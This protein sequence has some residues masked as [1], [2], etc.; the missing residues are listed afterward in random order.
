M[1]LKSLYSTNAVLENVSNDGVILS[2]EFE[3]LGQKIIW[4]SVKKK[5]GQEVVL[6]VSF[7]DEDKSIAVQEI[8]RKFS[9]LLVFRQKHVEKFEN[10][11]TVIFS[12]GGT[13]GQSTAWA[14]IDPSYILTSNE[15]SYSE[16]IWSMLSF[17]LEYKNSSSIYYQF[18]C[19]YKIIEL[20]NTKIEN[21]NGRNIVVED[22]D[23]I[24]SFI[25]TNV[26][27]VT[28]QAELRQ[29]KL[30][31]SRSRIKDKTLSGYFKHLL[32]DSFSHTGLLTKN[33]YKYGY[34]TLNPS[35]ISDELKFHQ[36]VG[37]FSQIADKLLSEKVI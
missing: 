25:N 15:P 8:V 9:S 26:P 14:A 23:S 3:F 17:Y 18:I 35:N 12:G 1:I 29:L 16:Q 34:P 2:H 33:N 32:R 7:D 5:L 37:I 13:V 30:K 19:L 36:G 22:P 28:D 11:T 24:R 27:L 21:R 4:E 10:R 20:K 31:V 6:S